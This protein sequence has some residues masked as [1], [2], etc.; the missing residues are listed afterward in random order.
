VARL[1]TRERF[2]QEVRGLFEAPRRIV[3]H[4]RPPLLQELG[5]KRKLPFGPGLKS[6]LTALRGMRKLRGR[7]FDIFGGFAVRREER[8]LIEWYR[9]IIETGLASLSER[10][11]ATIAELAGLPDGIRGYEDIKLQNVAEVRA[12]ADELLMALRAPST[13]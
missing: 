2:L 1:H 4:L 11:H 3:Y 5:L 8:R 10:T 9:R 6:G 13:P 12:R 7:A